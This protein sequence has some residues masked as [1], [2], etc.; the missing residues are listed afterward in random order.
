[1]ETRAAGRPREFDRDEALRAAALLF[2]KHGFSGTSTRGLSTAL[3]ISSSSLYA[4]FGSKSDLFNEAVRTYAQRYSA[5][6]D[7]A[8]A[9]PTLEK[10]VSRVLL[11]SA[12]EFGRTADGHPG[13]LTSSAVMADASSTLDVRKYVTDLQHRDEERL[14]ERME[15]EVAAGEASRVIEP[16]ALAGLVQTLWHGLAAR[17]D[18]GASPEELVSAAESAIACLPITLPTSARRVRPRGSSRPSS[19][20]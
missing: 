8:L 12:R 15:R 10:V 7:A 17:A 11:D 2:W 6:Y 20:Q 18:L 1:M 14:R 9:E 19:A 3:G 5:I 13:C 4:A 16:A